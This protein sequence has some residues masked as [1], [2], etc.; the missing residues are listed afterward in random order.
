[1]RYENTFIAE[2]IAVSQVKDLVFVGGVNRFL[3][4]FD[5][6]MFFS[7]LC[8]EQKHDQVEK[9]EQQEQNIEIAADNDKADDVSYLFARNHVSSLVQNRKHPTPR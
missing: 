8:S 5:V 1:M 9:N 4:R 6:R 2:C 7:E 3:R